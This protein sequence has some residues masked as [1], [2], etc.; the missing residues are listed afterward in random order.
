MEM[1]IFV[2]PSLLPHPFSRLALEIADV[3]ADG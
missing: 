1:A 2:P 3:L